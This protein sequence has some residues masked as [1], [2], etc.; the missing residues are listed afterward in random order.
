MTLL[1]RIF[2][3]YID[4]N[5]TL[6]I[7]ALVW[8][9]A[10][11]LLARFGNKLDF[12]VQLGL[13]NGLFAVIVLAPLGAAAYQYMLS[14]EV[15]PATMSVN[16]ADYA[17]S[18]YL[19]GG[20]A[21]PAEDFQALLGA[22]SQ[23]S[24]SVLSLAPGLGAGI[25]LVLLAG[26][27]VCAVRLSLSFGRL[28]RMLGSCHRWRRAGRVHL[29]LSDDALVPFSARGLVSHYVVIPSELLG[30][31]EYRCQKSDPQQRC[32]EWCGH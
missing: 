22:R 26:F 1:S 14:A 12:P 8:L 11:L 3:L 5:I 27:S 7:T 21:I 6:A 9:G 24:E 30:E 25:A 28:Y 20:I 29:L 13:L 15:V 31:P 23:L 16:L 17:V 10:K 19:R 4:V 18:Q 2:D 32:R